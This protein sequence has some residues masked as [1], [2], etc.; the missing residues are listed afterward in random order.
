[1][2]YSFISI[3]TILCNILFCFRLLNSIFPEA[4]E[5]VSAV[6]KNKKNWILMNDK[7]KQL[8]LVSNSSME[9]FELDIDIEGDE[10]DES[11]S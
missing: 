1:M 11:Q 7:I 10:E 6:E 4:N 9:I 5:V 3:N 2:G 8:Q